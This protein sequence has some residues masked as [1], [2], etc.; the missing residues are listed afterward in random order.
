MLQAS[1]QISTTQFFGKIA[2]LFKLKQH[3]IRISFTFKPK[4]GEEIK[5]VIED[6]DEESFQ[7]AL[8]IQPD[9]SRLLVEVKLNRMMEESKLDP[10]E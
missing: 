9:Y 10:D 2:S 4:N 1:S 8:E 6:G 3:S 7:H 5:I